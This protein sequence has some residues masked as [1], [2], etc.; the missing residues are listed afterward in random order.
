MR[1]FSF[2]PVRPQ[3]PL[4]GRQA[5]IGTWRGLAAAGCRGFVGPVPPPLSM[6]FVISTNTDRLIDNFK[7]VN[8][9]FFDYVWFE[10]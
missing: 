2:F 7:T 10:A 5:G 9:Y 8:G 1:L 4:A 6:R 3:E